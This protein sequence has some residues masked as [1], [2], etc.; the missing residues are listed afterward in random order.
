MIC[1]RGLT[2]HDIS[3]SGTAA[4][5][6]LLLEKILNKIR[7]S[8]VTNGEN[9]GSYGEVKGRVR[10]LPDDEDSSSSGP[11]MS[12]DVAWT[13]KILR[14]VTYNLRRPR[15]IFWAYYARKRDSDDAHFETGAIRNQWTGPRTNGKMFL[16]FIIARNMLIWHWSQ[17]VTIQMTFAR[18]WRNMC[19][20]RTKWPPCLPIG[21][22]IMPNRTQNRI[23]CVGSSSSEETPNTPKVLTNMSMAIRRTTF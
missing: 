14:D 21:Q 9:K 18:H 17:N 12:F 7:L 19:K 2:H 13:T 15:I 20:W 16:N 10:C 22:I 1:F 3:F 4:C 8:A 5:G 11:K 23:F 6:Y